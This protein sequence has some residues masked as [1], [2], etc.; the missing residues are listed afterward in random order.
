MGH[1][2]TVHTTVATIAAVLVALGIAAPASAQSASPDP[3]TPGTI[4]FLPRYDFHLDAQHLS[5]PDPRFV[6]DANFG[7]ALDFVDYGFGRATFLANYQVIL[8]E[9]I[10]N[11]DP[12]QG[13]YTL[14]GSASGRLH[15]FEAALVFHHVSRHLADR[16]KTFAIDWNMLGA[17]VEKAFAVKG[18]ELNPRVDVRGVILHSYVDYRWEVDADLRNVYPLASRVAAVSDV[19]LRLL[20][21]DGSQ[22]RGTQTGAKAEGGIRLGGKAGAVELFIAV[23]RRI[24]PYPTEFGVDTWA[25]AGFRLLSR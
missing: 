6:W 2:K 1:L 18:I 25:S 20:G 11:F 10:R 12:N 22:N 13:N 15:G 9:E 24:D 14:E 17:R 8:G 23:E 7:G 4:E 19:D 16:P 3:S 21:V 5:S